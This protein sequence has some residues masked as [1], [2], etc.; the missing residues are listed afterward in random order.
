MCVR[1]E[2]LPPSKSPRNPCS[3]QHAVPEARISLMHLLHLLMQRCWAL[4]VQHVLKSLELP[5]G[6]SV[7][8]G[9]DGLESGGLDFVYNQIL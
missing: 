8:Q 1:Y 3:T 9:C 7:C 5:I 2:V 4:V 6:R